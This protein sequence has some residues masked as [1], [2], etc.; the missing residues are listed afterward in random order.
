MLQSEEYAS[1]ESRHTVSLFDTGNTY[2][3]LISDLHLFNVSV[4]LFSRGGMRLANSKVD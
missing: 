1:H 2:Y 3:V 4:Y